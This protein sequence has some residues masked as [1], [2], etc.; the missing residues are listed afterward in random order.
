MNF[1]SSF[2]NEWKNDWFF[3]LKP[4]FFYVTR[5]MHSKSTSFGVENMLFYTITDGKEQVPISYFTAVSIDYLCISLAA[6]DFICSVAILCF[7]LCKNMTVDPSFIFVGSEKNWSSTLRPSS[8]GVHGEVATG[9]GGICWW[10]DDGQR[11]FPQV[12]QL[13]P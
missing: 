1:Y 10:G 5:N 12:R 8:E 9:C 4:V 2:V 7:I 11:P 3:F 6:C 13:H